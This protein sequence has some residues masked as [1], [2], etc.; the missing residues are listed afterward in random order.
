MLGMLN[1]SKTL[2]W[3]KQNQSLNKELL[4]Y[5]VESIDLSPI[6]D[7]YF[8]KI[9]KIGSIYIKDYSWGT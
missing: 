8:K 6:M 3:K 1:G 7:L 4:R 9:N 5:R 2:K